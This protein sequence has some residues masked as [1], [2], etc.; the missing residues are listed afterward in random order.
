MCIG[1]VL[2]ALC[3]SS[4]LAGDIYRYKTADGRTL[5][6]DSAI[7]PEGAL[8]S[9]K[10]TGFPAVASSPVERDDAQNEVRIAESDLMRAYNRL[11]A[12]VLPH[13]DEIIGL[14]LAPAR[15]RRPTLPKTPAYYERIDLLKAHIAEAQ[16]RLDAARERFYALN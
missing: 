13:S 5:F 6:T 7:G 12:N 10:V 14:P 3:C 8:E 1:L 11:T 4:A 2:W 16:K 9:K 15:G